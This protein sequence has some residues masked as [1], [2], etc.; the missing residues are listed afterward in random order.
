MTEYHIDTRDINDDGT[1]THRVDVYME[2]RRSILITWCYYDGSKRPFNKNDH[3]VIKSFEFIPAD[4]SVDYGENIEVSFSGI[5]PKDNNSDKECKFTL[6]KTHNT[7][8]TARP[9]VCSLENYDVAQS[10]IYARLPGS[11]FIRGDFIFDIVFNK[12]QTVQPMCLIL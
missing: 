11:E 5:Y 6:R 7:Y 1:Q 2:Q 9:V 8:K 12:T 3:A 10:K 4:N